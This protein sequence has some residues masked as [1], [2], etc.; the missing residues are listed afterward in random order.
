V[1]GAYSGIVSSIPLPWAPNPTATSAA[2]NALKISW[3][4]VAGA[5]GYEVSYATSEAGPFTVLPTTTLTSATITNLLT[6]STYTVRVRAYRTVNYKKVYGAYSS[7]ITG[8]PIPSTPAPKVVSGGFDSLNLSWAAIP[9]ATGY[10]VQW[11]NPATSTYETLIDTTT[12]SRLSTTGLVSGVAQSYRVYA[13]RLVGETKVYSQRFHR[14]YGNPAAFH[15]VGSETQCD[16][17]VH[18]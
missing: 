9:G 6:N 4:A 3:P 15:R 7:F 18:A 13:Y 1:Y 10:D 8:T 17:C 16:E 12:L 2:Y 5:N 11:L 14:Y